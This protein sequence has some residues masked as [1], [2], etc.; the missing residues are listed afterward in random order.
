MRLAWNPSD[1]TLR[2][3]VC[4]YV[5]KRK[6][7]LNNSVEREKRRYASETRRNAAIQ[8]GGEITS[9][10][11]REEKGGEEEGRQEIR[12]EGKR[13]K[14]NGTSSASLLSLCLCW[15]CEHRPLDILKP[16]LTISQLKASITKQ[17]LE[18][19]FAH[20]GTIHRIEI[21][22]SRGQA[23][24]SGIPVPEDRITSRDRQYASIEFTSPEAARLSLRL[25]GKEIDGCE[26]V[27]C[28]L[29]SS[30]DSVSY[31]SL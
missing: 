9:R 11:K 13:K 12:R 17:R 25:H 30:N 22:C 7:L 18:D 2:P 23:I 28:T 21:R 14:N 29:L 6:Y 27:A 26:I 5:R 10:S 8:K 31:E 20:C 3:Q 24:T 16:K 15:E 4:P 1:T 19:Y